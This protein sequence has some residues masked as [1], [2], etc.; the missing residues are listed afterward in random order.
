[1]TTVEQKT[2]FFGPEW[3]AAIRE[4]VE[5]GASEELKE[6]K[7]PS[8]WEWIDKARADYDSSW[9]IADTDLGRTLLVEWADGH[10][11]RAEIVDDDE[12]AGA[13]YLLTAKHAVWQ[14][15]HAGVDAGRL[16][17]CRD[18]ELRRGNVLQFY[19]AVYFVVESL[20]AIG[21]VPTTIG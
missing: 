12:A 7:L 8:Y 9:A 5:R 21:R 16:L 4:A 19:R 10:C 1:M 2:T 3:A 17:M 18:I 14:R 13:T 15:L 20:A 6:S 11:V